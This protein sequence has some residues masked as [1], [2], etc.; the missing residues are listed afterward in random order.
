MLK[1]VLMICWEIPKS[2]RFSPSVA[3]PSDFSPC[4]IEL[5]YF[6]GARLDLEHTRKIGDLN[7]LNETNIKQ[8]DNQYTTKSLDCM[9]VNQ[10]KLS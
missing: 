2:G 10:Q 8:C 5:N 7:V 3:L 6:D 1:D 4:S 9:S